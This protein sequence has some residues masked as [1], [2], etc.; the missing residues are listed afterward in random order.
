MAEDLS[1][2]AAGSM[3]ATGQGAGNTTDPER[4]RTAPGSEPSAAFPLDHGSPEVGAGN[5]AAGNRV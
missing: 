4:A 3:W 5:F 2:L 1:D